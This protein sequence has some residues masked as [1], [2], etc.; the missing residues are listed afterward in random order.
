MAGMNRILWIAGLTTA[1]CVW[2]AVTIGAVYA[3]VTRHHL[4]A[5][6]WGVLVSSG[7]I[8]WITFWYLRQKIAEKPKLG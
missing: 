5:K 1:L 6:G 2:C 3:L 4:N 8:G 7:Y